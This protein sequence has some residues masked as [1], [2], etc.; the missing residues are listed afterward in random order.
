MYVNIYIYIFIPA[1]TFYLGMRL[2]LINQCSN[3]TCFDYVIAALKPN[4][5]SEDAGISHLTTYLDTFFIPHVTEIENPCVW[6]SNKHCN[7]GGVK[8]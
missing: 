1:K 7:N 8:L 6:R 2:N 3:T 4:E 5:L